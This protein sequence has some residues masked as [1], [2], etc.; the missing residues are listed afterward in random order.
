MAPPLLLLQDI[1]LTFGGTPLL[2]QA[3]LSVSSGERLCLVGRNGSGKSTLLKIAAGLITPDRGQRFLQP[4]TTLRYLP[5]EPDLT[6]FSTTSAYVEAGLAPGDDTYRAQ[7]LLE[8]LGLAGTE[9]PTRLS[10]GEARRAALARLLAPEPDILLLDEPTN[11]LDLP[12]IEWLESELRSLRSALV[13]ISH[14]RRFMETLSRATVWLDRGTTRRLEQGFAAFEEWRDTVFEEEER[15]RHKLD[16][17]IA[18]ENDWLRYG[19][20]A[21]RKRNQGRLR[22]LHAMRQERRDAR[23]AVGDVKMTV[24]EGDISGKLVIEAV[25]ISKSYGTEPVVR[26]LSIRIARGDRIGIVGRNGAGKTTL[27]NMLTGQLA[28]DSG[29]V[30]IGANVAMASLDQGR[31]GLD[32]DVTLRDALTGGGSDTVMVGGTPKHVMSYLKDFLFTPDQAN[33]PIGKLSGGERGRLMLARA[34]AQP[35]NLLVLDEPTNDLDLETLDLLEEMIDSYSGTVILVS[36]DRDFL[37]RTVTSVLMAEGQGRWHD[38]AG[39]YSDMLAQ[40]GAGVETTSRGN[41][42]GAAGK[43]AGQA[44]ASRSEQD[45]RNAPKTKLSFRDKHAL[46]SLPGRM[47]ALERDIAKLKAVLD[48]PDL[49]AR[50]PARFAKASQA[51]SKAEADL[52]ASEEEWL[53]L[54]M[55]REE[56]ESGG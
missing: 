22:A 44:A 16:R 25:N 52:A 36:H 11:H 45:E 41:G 18:Q 23:R 55:L 34:L 14:D 40:R 50:D 35:S 42:G 1:A 47:A 8:Q 29:T 37:D 2:E 51:M 20:T 4:G 48:D 7:Y 21:R 6:G 54:E 39:G 38:Y 24:S 10:G 28:P 26:D 31:A 12:V 46:E 15:D 30:K 32:P 3:S 17:R 56:I 53:R 5:Q 33:M 9:D 19:V 49:Y 13:L 27:I 43:V